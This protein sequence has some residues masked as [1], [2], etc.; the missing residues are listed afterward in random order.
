M[1]AATAPN[2]IPKM[3]GEHEQHNNTTHSIHRDNAVTKN[4][5]HKQSGLT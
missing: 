5:V 3:N 1:T 2:M 4:K